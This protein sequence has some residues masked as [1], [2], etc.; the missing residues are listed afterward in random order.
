M[1]LTMEYAYSFL[2]K[3]HFRIWVLYLDN[4]VVKPVRVVHDPAGSSLTFFPR[5]ARAKVVA[6]F[7]RKR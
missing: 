5:V 2:K 1:V 7:M 3:P 4:P 6:N